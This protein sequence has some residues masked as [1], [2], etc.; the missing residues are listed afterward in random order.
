[1]RLVC[2]S[3]INLL[4]SEKCDS[5]VRRSRVKIRVHSCSYKA[6]GDSST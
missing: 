1:M 4:M 3:S 2:D 6:E 5:R